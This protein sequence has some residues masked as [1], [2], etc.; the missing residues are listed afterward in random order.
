MLEF[1]YEFLWS[2]GNIFATNDFSVAITNNFGAPPAILNPPFPVGASSSVLVWPAGYV[3][4]T[5]VTPS[6]QAPFSTNVLVLPNDNVQLNPPLYSTNG[7]PLNAVTVSPTTRTFFQPDW[8]LN[9][10]NRLRVIMTDAASGRIIDYV[11]LGGLG[12]L[13]GLDSQDD[14]LTNLS[15]M[16]FPTSDLNIWT[17]SATSNGIP[18]GFFNQYQISARLNGAQPLVNY[19]YWA[20][21]P[22]GTPPNNNSVVG[23]INGFNTWLGSGDPG[24]RQLPYSPTTEITRKFIHGPRTTRWFIT[25]LVT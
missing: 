23:A 2:P 6:F 13:T 10:T 25:R 14:V 5:L 17:P 16:S 11:Q 12:Q 20:S 15:L 22:N 24:P 18:I 1:V 21:V 8:G 9:I 4:N 7:N 19:T 3:N